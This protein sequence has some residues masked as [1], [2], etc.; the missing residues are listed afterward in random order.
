[1]PRNDKYL[2]A[3]A[4]NINTIDL[5]LPQDDFPKEASLEC[6]CSGIGEYNTPIVRANYIQ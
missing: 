4:Q 3:A 2:I 5:H 6:E 1:V